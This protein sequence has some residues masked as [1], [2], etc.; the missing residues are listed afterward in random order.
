M[1]P[2]S[3]D[4]NE[5][6]SVTRGPVSGRAPT[7]ARRPAATALAV[8]RRR[9]RD[10]AYSGVHAVTAQALG[11]HRSASG[12][13]S[14]ITA[15]HPGAITAGAGALTYGVTLSNGVAGIDRPAGFTNVTTISDAAIEADG[16]YAVGA[17]TVDPQWT[18]YFNSPSTWLATVLALNP[19]P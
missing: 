1:E 5:R 12:S 14:S 13:G 17:G 15:V 10:S 8:S 3:I 7:V 11:A 2:A 16:E 9:R 4:C 19:A 6:T 18:W